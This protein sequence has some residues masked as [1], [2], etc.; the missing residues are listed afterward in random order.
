MAY[1]LTLVTLFLFSV[2]QAVASP[3]IA[4]D[5]NWNLYAFGLDGKDYNAG[6]QDKW[7]GSMRWFLCT[8]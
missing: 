6:T 7:T 5:A 1:L 3:C 2:S 8:P 4:F